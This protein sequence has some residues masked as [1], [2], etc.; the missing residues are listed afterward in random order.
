MIF[1]T[2]LLGRIIFSNIV[3]KMNLN[4]E[5]VKKINSFLND[6]YSNQHACLIS[7]S[8]VDRKNNEYSDIDVCVFTKDRNTVFNETLPYKD[9]KIQAIIIPVQNVQE[10]LW[11]DYITGKG[12]IINMISKGVIIFD[13]CNFLKYL[14][15]HTKSLEETG[16]RPLSDSEIYMLRVKITSLLFDVMGGNNL[17]ELLYSINSIVDLIS[18]L[19][20]KATGNWCGNGKHRM[21]QIKVLD[22]EFQKK[23]IN[24]IEDI[25][26]KKSKD[27]FVHLIKNSLKDY[28]GLLPYHSKA[29]LLSLVTT[30][31]L[32]IEINVNRSNKELTNQN[33][34]VL[35]SFIDGIK[36][37]KLEYYFFSSKAVGMNKT[38]QNIYMIIDAEK[39]FINDYLIDRLNFFVINKPELSA[40][41]FPF[42]FDPRYRFSNNE[43]YNAVAPLFYKTSN[44][45]IRKNNAIYNQS[46]QLKFS[47][48][49]FKQIKFNWFKNDSTNFSLFL[50]YLIECWIIFSYDDGLS[51]TTSRLLKNKKNVLDKFER[52]YLNQKE[53]LEK[54]YKLKYSNENNF[55]QMMQNISEISEIENIPLYKAYLLSNHDIEAKRWSLYREITFKTLSIAFVDNRFISYIPFVVKKTEING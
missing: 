38:E 2:Y 50:E 47:L 41:S 31:Y 7:G 32:V 45:I 8:Y 5:I 43:I 55:S 9:L 30:N 26:V 42:Q 49:L 22:N 16:G 15:P 28:G 53:E 1:A 39:D 4:K 17:D 6:Y 13:N 10:I 3:K 48:D 14:I 35:S 51:F 21:R 11:V 24:S 52:M 12:S 19:K 27:S 25:Y 18:E 29:V 20:L 36:S 34:K 46:F 44:L 40:L 23:L 33:I 54:I 37:H